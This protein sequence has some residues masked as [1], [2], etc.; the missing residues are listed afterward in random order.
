M[1][2]DPLLYSFTE[3][4]EDDEELYNDS[5]LGPK[6]EDVIEE[7]NAENQK[8]IDKLKNTEQE[9]IRCGIHLDAIRSDE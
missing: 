2:D 1:E 6:K 7:E 3:E 5:N 9:L 4:L 8:V